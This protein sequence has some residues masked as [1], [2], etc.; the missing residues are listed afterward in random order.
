MSIGEAAIFTY[1]SSIV[2]HGE[3]QGGQCYCIYIYLLERGCFCLSLSERMICHSLED[4]GCAQTAG[5]WEYEFS[6]NSE[7][8]LRATRGVQKACRHLS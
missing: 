7:P 2:L 3:L 8:L 6:N 4:T 5:K 1:T